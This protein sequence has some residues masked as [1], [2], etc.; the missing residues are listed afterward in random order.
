M[1]FP[2]TVN[3]LL[4]EAAKTVW[5]FGAGA[6]STAPYKVPVQG[7][8]LEEF[9]KINPSGKDGA[10]QEFMQY[11]E[12][13]RIA[14]ERIQPGSTFENVTLEEVFSAYEIQNQA[15]WATDAEKKQARDSIQDL[16][17]M[18]IRS[19]GMRGR[20]D[21][22]KFRPHKRKHTAS[23]Y[24]ELLEKL[25]PLKCSIQTLKS[26]VL[27]T[28]NYDIS[29]DRCLINMKRRGCG[30]LDLDYGVEFANYRLTDSF[31]RPG[32]RSVLLLRLHGGLNWMRCLACQALF[33]TVDAHARMF[34]TQSC[35]M[36]GSERLDYII[37]HP[38]FHRSYTDPVLQMVWGRLLEELRHA[39]RW[40]FVGYSLPP[41]D[42][43]LRVLLR[44]A[45]KM[46]TESG[47]DTNI[48][49]VG[50]RNDP[51]DERWLEVGNSFHD[52]FGYHAAAWEQA[53]D[54]F[55]GFVCS[56]KK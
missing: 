24:A 28:M 6:S 7:K 46:R 23:P 26:H 38:S 15:G 31:T 50:K 47:K 1:S 14:C 9:N 52:L 18:L 16:R 42:V 3:F 21:A 4:S 35:R 22:L 32:E 13:V 41:A 34:E 33:T 20:G 30:L 36:C 37:V 17:R 25:F 44:H 11:R 53:E 10:K 5:F 29:L 56:I 55:S 49:W 27:V 19:T 48:L 40:I 8:L 43:D 39:D 54:G 45:L 51:T 12:R 2:C